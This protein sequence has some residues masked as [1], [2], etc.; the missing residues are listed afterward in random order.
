MGHCNQRERFF[1]FFLTSL[2]E[3][4]LINYKIAPF[5]SA[6]PVILS[7][8]RVVQP[9]L[10]LRAQSQQG[11]GLPHSAHLLRERTEGGASWTSL[12]SLGPR[13]LSKPP[14]WTRA[15]HT[16]ATLP[17]STNLGGLA[18]AAQGDGHRHGHRHR[19]NWK[20]RLQFPN[21]Q[22]W[23]FPGLISMIQPREFPEGKTNQLRPKETRFR[24]TGLEASARH[25]GSWDRHRDMNKSMAS[26]QFPQGVPNINTP[27]REQNPSLYLD[28]LPLGVSIIPSPEATVK[29]PRAL[30]S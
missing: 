17:P 7:E 27:R 30:I 22:S 4:L 1:F 6:Q 21:Q 9:A 15:H 29:T 19:H 16:P 8:F 5:A 24:D 12:L 14:L 13:L 20:G 2:A 11:T 28:A 10:L 3:G 18:M 23:G 25:P 26:T